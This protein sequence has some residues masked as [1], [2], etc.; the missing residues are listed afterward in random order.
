MRL[1]GSAW[2]GWVGLG[3]KLGRTDNDGTLVWNEAWSKGLSEQGMTV[4]D[5][6]PLAILALHIAGAEPQDGDTVAVGLAAEVGADHKHS[7][8]RHLASYTWERDMWARTGLNELGGLEGGTMWAS[9]SSGDR[10]LP[11][12]GSPEQLTPER[13][14]ECAALGERM[15]HLRSPGDHL[16]KTSPPARWISKGRCGRAAGRSQRGELYVVSTDVRGEAWIDELI[17]RKTF[18]VP[19]ASCASWA[20]FDLHVKTEKM[21]CVSQAAKSANYATWFRGQCVSPNQVLWLQVDTQPARTVNENPRDD[22]GESGMLNIW[23]LVC[24]PGADCDGAQGEGN[25]LYYSKARG[26][27]STPEIVTPDLKARSPVLNI[28]TELAAYAAW[29]KAHGL[30]TR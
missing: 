14:A 19:Q 11:D 24:Q 20:S 8:R 18:V 30:T 27:V 5:E 25:L 17:S 9:T 3:V 12:M 2:Q 16:A 10:L 15:V 1:F 28:V 6:T 26:D 21:S 29:A 7:W 13:T 23:S 22:P 4:Q